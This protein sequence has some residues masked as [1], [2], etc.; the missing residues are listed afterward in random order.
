MTHL[1]GNKNIETNIHRMFSAPT[2][3][4]TSFFISNHDLQLI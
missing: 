4:K 2:T 3:E 1:Y